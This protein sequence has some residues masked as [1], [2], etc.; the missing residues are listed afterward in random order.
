[1][2]IA[3]INMLEF[4]TEDDESHFFF[5]EEDQDLDRIKEIRSEL[6]GLIGDGLKG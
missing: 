4:D 1:M 3:R 6:E 2:S 5:D